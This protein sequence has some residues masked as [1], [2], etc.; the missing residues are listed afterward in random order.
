MAAGLSME[1]ENVPRLRKQL[2]EKCKLT[3]EDLC[4][5]ITIDVAMPFSYI[6]RELVEQLDLL[7]P[8]GKGN[9]KPI[10]AVRNVELLGARILGK[11]RN[12]LKL[13]VR[14]GR[15]VS[16][17]A[18]CFRDAENFLACVKER[19]GQKAEEELLAGRGRDIRMSLTYY[20]DLN[21]YQGQMT[22]QIVITHY[23]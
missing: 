3:K 9:T 22:P 14:D 1:E 18:L 19:Y 20:P 5:K 21:E 13:R 15:G 17:D 4:P 8:F 12:V 11:N 2:N 16:I 6:R 10:F 7:E 23:Q